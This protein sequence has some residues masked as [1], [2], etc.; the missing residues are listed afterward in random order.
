MSETP[1]TSRFGDILQKG[2]LQREFL[3]QVQESYS[4]R[5]P[6]DGEIGQEEDQLLLQ[7]CIRVALHHQYAVDSKSQEPDVVHA[8]GLLDQTFRTQYQ[9][10]GPLDR[11]LVG[12]DSVGVTEIMVNSYNDIYVEIDGDVIHL[13]PDDCFV[14]EQQL[15]DVQDRLA[16]ETNRQI[17]SQFP[18]V[19]TR[20]KYG[21]RCQL[22]LNGEPSIDGGTITLRRFPD[23]PLTIHDLL[24]FGSVDAR[25]A[26]FIKQAVEAKAN[27]LIV[28][29]TGSGK[30]TLLN[31]CSNFIPHDE[32]I[33]TIEDAAELQL[34][35]PHKLRLETRKES[36]DAEGSKISMEDLVKSALRMRPDRIVVGEC[37]GGEA[38]DMLQAMGTGHD[39]SMSTYHASSPQEAMSRLETLCLMSDIVMPIEAIRSIIAASIDIIV[40]CARLRNPPGEDGEREAKKSRLITQISEIGGV[41]G[42]K[43]GQTDIYVKERYINSEGKGRWR[44]KATGM[45][46]QIVQTKFAEESIP[47]NPALFA[48][49]RDTKL[50]SS[51]RKI[52][53]S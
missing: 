44:M 23:T 18:I 26:T 52:A 20:D 41:E 11:W 12:K 51:V 1:P 22:T 7:T 38:I 37:R 24:K 39:G 49:D 47:F 36:A 2:T 13:D 53:E 27:M 48:T 28:G 6:T 45:V 5:L 30:T 14:S 42:D 4:T 15:R 29:G 9:G 33:I 21:N 40:F 50:P 16:A 43:I 19:E 10:Y 35:A 31:I 25:A 17:N 34:Q 8:V 3:A 32:R 46:P